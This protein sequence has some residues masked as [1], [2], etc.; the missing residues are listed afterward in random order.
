MSPRSCLHLLKR[1]SWSCFFIAF[2]QSHHAPSI[3]PHKPANPVL[4]LRPHAVSSPPFSSSFPHH[5]LLVVFIEWLRMHQGFSLAADWPTHV[6]VLA[7]SVQ[8]L[9]SLAL[10]LLFLP[11]DTPLLPG[12]FQRQKSR[13]GCSHP[14]FFGSYHWRF[15][16]VFLPI[17]HFPSPLLFIFPNS[18]QPSSRS[19]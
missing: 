6:S 19:S 13:C 1:P 2:T 12:F 17:T 3:F 14:V 4:L 11:V 5:P 16:A 18:L 9:P 7:L 8:S 10:S 15:S